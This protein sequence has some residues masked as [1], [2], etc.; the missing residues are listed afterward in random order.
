MQTDIQLPKTT[1]LKIARLAQMTGRTPNAML[2]FVLRDG[3]QAVELSVL[4]NA[5]ADQEFAAGQ[6]VPHDTVMQKA[7]AMLVKGPSA[8]LVVA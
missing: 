7:R 1:Q 5:L 6:V 2:R 8:N 3:L 4:E